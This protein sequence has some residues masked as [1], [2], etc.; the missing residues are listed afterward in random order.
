MDA[1]HA[2]PF[3]GV[4]FRRGKLCA[5][6]GPPLDIVTIVKCFGIK[7]PQRVTTNSLLV[8]KNQT[9]LRL[10][11]EIWPHKDSTE[12]IGILA[13]ERLAVVAVVPGLETN[14]VSAR[15][16]ARTRRANNALAHWVDVGEIGRAHV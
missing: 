2:R 5:Q 14:V 11:S 7:R 8:C 16:I 1:F 9:Q 15:L 12:G 10:V 4:A 6:T 3:R 13:I